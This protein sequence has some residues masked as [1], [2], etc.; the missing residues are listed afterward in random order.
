M[1]DPTITKT[2]VTIHYESD[3]GYHSTSVHDSALNPSLAP[4]LP[5]LQGIE[6]LARLCALF[7]MEDEAKKLVNDA[8]ARLADWRAARAES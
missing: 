4:H 1:N 2:E 3:D 7:G 5:L 6:E 8:F